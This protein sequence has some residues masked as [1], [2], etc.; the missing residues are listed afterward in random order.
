MKKKFAISILFIVLTVA[1]LLAFAA[2]NGPLIC[3]HD[4]LNP[5]TCTTAAT[6]TL[7]GEE[8]G[9]PL[10]HNWTEATCTTAKT[11]IRCYVAEGNPLGHDCTEEIISDATCTWSGLKRVKC[12]N[13]YYSNTEYI[14]ALGH[15][16]VV[17]KAIEPTCTTTGLTEGSHCSS[18]DMIFVRQ[19]V[20]KATGHTEV[21]DKAVPFTCTTDGKTEG[22]HCSVCN[23]IL[24]EQNV[25]PAGHISEWIID[26]PATCTKAG[27]KHQ[28]C[29]V[30]D[31]TIETKSI[32]K[33]GHTDGQWIIDSA[34]TCTKEGSKHQ[35]CSTCNRT[36]KTEV[37]KKLD[38][39]KQSFNSAQQI[40]DKF[41]GSWF[42]GMC[43]NN[44]TA[45]YAPISAS[46][47]KNCFT[48]GESTGYELYVSAGGG[49]GVYSYFYMVY[50]RSSGRILDIY[51]EGY[52][53]ITY[54]DSN[55]VGH[56]LAV[57]VYI[58]DHAGQI[59]YDIPFVD[60]SDNPN[61]WY[62]N[63]RWVYDEYRLVK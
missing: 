38:H 50:E 40:E 11:C 62:W 31:A 15:T 19:E 45:E 4:H 60:L 18:C 12:K 49:T 1:T 35:I 16:T 48:Y 25:I 10:G 41:Y 21:V 5:A 53:S 32:P 57:L 8:Q 27:I 46:F 22:K 20:V 37:I 58:A 14:P 13:C 24:I 59:I 23:E 33:K 42:C 61:A 28:I 47:R 51:N 34:A 29:S 39:T 7:C 3:T 56:N 44:Y 36:M 54:I 9:T 6:C 2:C 52:A 30:C 55:Y 43:K 26:I 63:S 17:D